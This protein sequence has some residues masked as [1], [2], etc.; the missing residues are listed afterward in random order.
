MVSPPNSLLSITKNPGNNM[1]GNQR[2]SLKG[3]KRKANSDPRTGGSRQQQI[4]LWL[5]PS[6]SPTEEGGQDPLFP[7]PQPRNRR[8]SRSAHPFPLENGSPAGSTN[9]DKSGAH[10][11]SNS[12]GN[13]PPSRAPGVTV[14]PSRIETPYPHLEAPDSMAWG[15]S[16]HQHQ[17][18]PVR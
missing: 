16:L 1:R 6:P 13:H 2:R 14:Q 11:Q 7:K 8:Q 12:L 18:G 5:P 4:T 15:N 10:W 17:Q 3:G 9:K